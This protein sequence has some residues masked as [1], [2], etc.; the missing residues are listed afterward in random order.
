MARLLGVITLVVGAISVSSV[1]R[2]DE[3]DECGGLLTQGIMDTLNIAKTA[4][5]K[6]ASV[7]QMCEDI[8]TSKSEGKSQD[9]EASYKV[10][11]AKYGVGSSFAESFDKHYCSNQTADLVDDA[12][13]NI[14]KN[15]VDPVIVQGYV[16]CKNSVAGGLRHKI[17][18]VNDNSELDIDVW[19]SSPTVATKDV[20]IQKIETS[21]T[22]AVCSGTLPDQMR[23]EPD[24]FI[25]SDIR[26]ISC[27]R[28]IDTVDR[29]EGTVEIKHGLVVRIY[30][31]LGPV[32]AE[33]P[34]VETV[35]APAFNPIRPFLVPKGM[36]AAFDS[37]A[38]GNQVCPPGWST[39]NDSAGR[40]IIG[41]GVPNEKY[42]TWTRSGSGEKIPLTMRM[43]WSV[44]G[45]E[46]HILSIQEIP[47]HHFILHNLRPFQPAGDSRNPNVTG[48]TGGA[49]WD[50]A[51][52]EVGGDAPHNVLPPYIA[53]YYCRKD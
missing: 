44:G 3:F 42:G 21:P 7:H 6:E 15:Q 23:K 22:D 36:I 17:L 45:E 35:V 8:A 37:S 31:N 38:S 49:G 46:S 5:K 47:R 24:G 29:P 12:F 51:T 32:I 4:D 50:F 39:F 33:L 1:S 48:I 26:T 30:S 28:K 18:R 27:A 11:S 41:A 52:N 2:A 43:P 16:E 25:L 13:L 10:F 34:K 14:V 40:V 9:I 19:K 20:E 53:L